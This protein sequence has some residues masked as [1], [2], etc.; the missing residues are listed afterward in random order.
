LRSRPAF[1]HRVGATKLIQVESRNV[2]RVRRLAY[3]RSAGGG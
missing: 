3:V 1:A 2:E